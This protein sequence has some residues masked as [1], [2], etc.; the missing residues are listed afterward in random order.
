MNSLELI[1][2]AENNL[3]YEFK[4]IEE[5]AYIN[6]EKIL[7]TFLKYSVRDYHFNTSTGY[8]YGDL[9]RDTLESIYADIFNTEDAIV[10]SQIV[11]GTHAI[12]ACLFGLLKHGDELI[13]I[14]GSPY[15]TLGEVIGNKQN[16]PGTLIDKGIKYKEVALDNNL[17]PD[18]K[19]IVNSISANSKVIL[20]QKS[21]G[22]S[23]RPSLTNIQ[24]KNIINTIKTINS[25]AIIMVDNCY[26]EFVETIEPSEVGA[27]I[28]AG[29][30]IKNPGG[31]IVP[32]GGYIAGKKELVDL[33][34]YQLTA[35]GLG[36]DLGA[37]L[38]NTRHLYHGLFL[39]PHTVSQALKG[40]CLLSFILEEY[41][42]SV[43]PRWNEVRADIVQ[44]ITFNNEE[45]VLA[46][47]QIIQN[48]SPVDSGVKLEYAEIP[49]YKDKVVMAAGTFI[50]GSSIEISCDAPLR[51]PYTAYLQGGLTY[52]HC[53]FVMKNIIDKLL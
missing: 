23:L 26:G 41:G 2:N 48:S 49:G 51:K 31:G 10:R 35:P 46:F 44:A 24:I 20:I 28:I 30:L 11:S 22:Y 38:I 50:Q 27:D 53:R 25:D 43:S 5:T 37:S 14:I 19:A 3:Y 16:H 9:G 15:D 6:Q 45:E 7:N 8:G 36:K 40:A 33:V 4:K 13:S 39:A 34:S 47:C 12:S 52:E 17:N 29:S 42:Y 32:S 21:R 1:R 18:I